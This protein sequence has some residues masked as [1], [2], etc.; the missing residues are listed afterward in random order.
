LNATE[1]TVDERQWD[2]EVATN[3]LL[4]DYEDSIYQVQKLQNIVAGLKGTGK[5][6]SSTRELLEYY[7]SSISAVRI[8]TKG[9]YMQIDQ[10]IG[11]L[12]D[13]VRQKCYASFAHKKSVR[14]LLNAERQIAVPSHRCRAEVLCKIAS[15]IHT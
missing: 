5:I 1:T 6:I 7:Y 12:Y 10:Q 4:D 15:G 11:K 14:M 2:I 9:R 3:K 13:V 8:P